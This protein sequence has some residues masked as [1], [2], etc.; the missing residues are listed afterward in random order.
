M[1]P[2]LTTET[3]RGI[4][5]GIPLS[6]DEEY[7]LDEPA[8]R[9]NLR[10]LVEVRPHGIY[11]FGSTGEF[12]AVDDDEFRQVVDILIEEVCPSGIPTQAGCNALVTREI[13]DKLKYVQQAGVDG[14]QV[15]LPSWMK[16]TEQEIVQ[17]WR[18]IS[19]A[20]PDLPL[21]SYN[22]SRTKWYMYGEQYRKIL[23]V[24]PN[25]IGIK[26]SG[27]P[28]LD[29]N[30]LEQPVAMTPEISHSLGF[31]NDLVRGM[32]FG[33]RGCYS[34]WISAWPQRTLSMFELADAGRWEEA[35]AVNSELVEVAKFIWGMAED[36]GLGM[37]DPIVDKGFG[38]LTGFLTG[39]QRTRPP[40]IG[41]PDGALQEIRQRVAERY[42]EFIWQ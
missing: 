8:Y 37:M 21:T 23:E 22:V 2:K 20:V 7:H 4:W 11:I 42:P 17:F 31:E 12:Y 5:A 39:H 41:W 19:R 35:E 16:L 28:E 36:R 9:E 10:R 13:I 29:L 27:S 32:R 1:S 40:Y 25:L 15:A 14:G 18:D 34:S 6:W 33:I 26:W 24:A 38:T 3:L 30:R